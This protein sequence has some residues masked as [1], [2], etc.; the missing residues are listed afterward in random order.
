MELKALAV[1]ALL[2]MV[3]MVFF[4]IKV[5]LEVGPEKTLSTRD[6]PISLS[7]S[8]GRL[9]RALNNHFEGLI[10]FSIATVTVTLMQ[11]T[12][13]ATAISSV[14]YCLARLIYIPAYYYSWVPL[15]SIVWMI[16]WAA[17]LF[18]LGVSLV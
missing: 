1:A 9:S 13:E 17:T 14:L 5:N 8:S 3:H 11:K 4:A 18:I 15:R 6:T 7:H 16:G 12:T 10:L 2:Q